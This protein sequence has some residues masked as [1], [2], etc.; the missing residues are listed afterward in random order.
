M[1]T[2]MEMQ[3]KATVKYHFTKVIR[4]GYINTDEQ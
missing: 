4:D 2:D 1:N 3:I